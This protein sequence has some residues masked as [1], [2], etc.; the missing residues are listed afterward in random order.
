MVDISVVSS[1]MEYVESVYHLVRVRLRYGRHIV[2]PLHLL[3][4][5][6][7]AHRPEIV[8]QLGE[9]LHTNDHRRDVL[10]L[11]EPPSVQTRSYKPV[12]EKD[13]T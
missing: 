3:S 12:S 8:L 9:V 13:V 7:P 2:Q 10:L 5:Q 1:A 6:T 11:K 4:S